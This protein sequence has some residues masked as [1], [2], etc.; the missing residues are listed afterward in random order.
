MV[1]KAADTPKEPGTAVVTWK[2]RMA[3]VTAQ[4]QQTEASKGG[5]LS[6][7]S[8]RLS[9]DD[10]PIAG[11]KINVIVADFV[12]E[13]TWYVDDYNAMKPASPACYAL[14]REEEGLVPHADSEDQ[15]HPQC[16]DCPM[17][18][19]GSY[20]KGGRGK[21]CKNTRRIAVIPADVLVKGPEAIKKANVVMCKLPVTSIKIFSKFVNQVTRVLGKPPFGVV[22]E[23]SLTPNPATIFQVNWKILENVTDETLLQALYEKH[24]SIEKM[25]FQPYPKIDGEPVNKSTKY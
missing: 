10:T 7:K 6:F 4:A 23:L 22:V 12:L 19:W 9:Y 16:A 18:E 15:Q 17:N 1:T 20:R 3:A 21:D 24:V 14:G 2:D 11:D 25:M 13:N 5:F 8:G